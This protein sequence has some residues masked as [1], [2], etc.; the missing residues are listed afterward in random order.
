MKIDVIFLKVI[1]RVIIKYAVACR[2]TIVTL[3]AWYLLDLHLDYNL[4]IYFSKSY[5]CTIQHWSCQLY[6]KKYINKTHK[7]QQTKLQNLHYKYIY[8]DSEH[9]TLKYFNFIIH[10]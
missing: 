2:V 1:A 4:L 8:T 10:S 6:K 5:G 3:V 9:M 7:T